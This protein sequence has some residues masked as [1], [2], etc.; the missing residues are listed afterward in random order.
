MSRASELLLKMKNNP[1]V[2][3]T[4]VTMNE[5]SISEQMGNMGF[6]FVWI[7]GEHSPL[8][9]QSILGHII[10]CKAGNTAA[11]VRIPWND[12]VLVKPILE[13]GPDGIIFP[14]IRTAEE[15]RLAVASTTYPPKGIRGFGPRRANRYG[16]MSSSEYIDN[17]QSSIIRIMQIEHIDAINNLESILA[18][19]GVDAIVAGP[20]DLSGSVNLLGQI[21]HPE[22]LKLLDRMA[23]AAKKAG[24]PFG[25]SFGIDPKSIE[26]WIRRGVSFIA[27]GN[28][29]SYILKAGSETM[30]FI[31]DTA[32]K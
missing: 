23:E 28:D 24:K 29:S 1:P 32:G 13:M 15:A 4:H 31:K 10:A 8:D 6:E 26:D 25:A 30:K 5:I 22:M 14:F 16:T 12:P 7:E 19:E 27:S 17:V 2:I 11:F 3:G 21:R 9:K 18:V 20:N